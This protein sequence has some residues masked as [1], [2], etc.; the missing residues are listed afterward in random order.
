MF[1]AEQIG[2]QK[3][4]SVQLQLIQLDM[5]IFIHHSLSISNKTAIFAALSK[6]TYVINH[7]LLVLRHIVVNNN[8]T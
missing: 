5:W 1:N 8:K 2:M 7:I 6:P 3:R 4:F